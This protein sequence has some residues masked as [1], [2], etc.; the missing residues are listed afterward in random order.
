VHQIEIS[1]NMTQSE[2]PWWYRVFVHQ[3]AVCRWCAVIQPRVQHGDIS[4]FDFQSES[5]LQ[6]HAGSEFDILFPRAFTQDNFHLFLAQDS[7]LLDSIDFCEVLRPDLVPDS[8][9]AGKFILKIDGNLRHFNQ[10]SGELVQDAEH[11]EVYYRAKYD[12]VTRLHVRT[13]EENRRLFQLQ[14]EKLQHNQRTRN[15]FAKCACQ[16]R[17]VSGQPSLIRYISRQMWF[18]RWHAELLISEVEAIE[19]ARRVLAQN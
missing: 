17:F 11:T 19:K 2:F 7:V 5:A 15:E 13:L 12:G 1:I 9:V 4:L 10:L 14:Q 3:R 6:G 18:A 16:G 8:I